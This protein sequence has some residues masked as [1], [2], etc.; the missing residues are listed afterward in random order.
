LRFS[1]PWPTFTAYER[2]VAQETSA[3]QAGKLG[4]TAAWRD[5]QRIDPLS[6]AA[7][8]G[9]PGRTSSPRRSRN[10]ADV[11]DRL[12]GLCICRMARHMSWS[13]GF[14]RFER[15]ALPPCARTG[16][17]CESIRMFRFE[18]PSLQEAHRRPAAAS[19]G[20]FRLRP[21]TKRTSTAATV[22]LKEGASAYGFPPH[23]RA[24]FLAFFGHDLY[25]FQPARRQNGLRSARWRSA[26]FSTIHGQ[27]RR[28]MRRAFRRSP[29]CRQLRRTSCRRS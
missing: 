15:R 2:N 28:R 5:A 7:L 20:Y 26:G 16:R 8:S 14:P 11:V 6:V 9:A 13:T 22:Q 10:L 3:R 12:A 23:T 19:D 4:C 29:L 21:P 17:D 18:G 24:T 25:R 27:C 1:K